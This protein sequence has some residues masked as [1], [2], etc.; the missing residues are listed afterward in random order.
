MKQ[1]TAKK[2]HK[3][4]IL[5][6]IPMTGLL[7]S[8]WHLSYV[9]LVT[10]TNWSSA[11]AA[12][13]LDHYSPMKFLVADAR[14]IVTD[15]AVKNNFE[16][17]FFID[18]DVCLPY[19]TLTTL[20]KYM[21]KGDVPIFGGLY[22]TKSVPAEP[23]VYRG[24][25]NGFFDKWK[26]G[27]KI[28]VDGMGLGCTVLNVKLLRAIWENSEEYEVEPGVRPR[29]VFETPST[30]FIDPETGAVNTFVGTEDLAFYKRIHEGGYYSKAG[31]PKIQRKKY[32][33]LL[34]TNIFC[35]HVDFN[36]IM[37]PSMGEEKDYIRKSKK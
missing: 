26:L 1:I 2:A 14:N 4:R 17:L 12:R 3:H 37:Y 20:N 27:D 15:Q 8:E 36:G 10:P 25:G 22:F 35:P 19:N 31:F 32:P 7:R 28:W 13:P 9:G 16:W 30:S 5:I 23:L 33:L 18:H 34:D 11:H 6:G 21:I 29:R 24:S